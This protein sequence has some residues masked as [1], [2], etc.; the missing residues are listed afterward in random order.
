MPA[1]LEEEHDHV[2]AIV[3]RSGCEFTLT[4]KEWGTV[5][6]AGGSSSLPAELR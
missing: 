6:S 5:A 4:K 1:N 2:S 3:P